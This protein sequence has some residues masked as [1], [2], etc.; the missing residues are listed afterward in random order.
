MLGE[1]LGAAF[2]EFKANWQQHMIPS[3]IVFG[4]SFVGKLI[5]CRDSDVSCRFSIDLFNW[6]IFQIVL[7]GDELC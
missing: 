7:F 5:Q 1:W 4:V 3:L 6:K 2:S